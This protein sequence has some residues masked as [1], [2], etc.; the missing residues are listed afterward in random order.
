MVQSYGVVTDDDGERYSTTEDIEADKQ[1]VEKK[2]KNKPPKQSINIY[3]HIFLPE[4]NN[5][6]KRNNIDMTQVH[7]LE[8]SLFNEL[9][10]TAHWFWDMPLTV[11]SGSTN[12]FIVAKLQI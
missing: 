1:H 5:F 3:D 12:L 4:F 9:T 2:N 8:Q 10:R 7:G 11:A 6:C